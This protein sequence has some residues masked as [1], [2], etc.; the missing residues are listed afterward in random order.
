MQHAAAGLGRPAGDVEP[1]PVEP[2]PDEPA[3][4]GRRRSRARRRR[5]SARAPP[6][7]RRASRHG[8]GGAVRACA[9]TRCPAARPGPRPGRR[10]ATA[11]GSGARRQVRRTARSV[12]SASTDQN[13]TRSATTAAASQPVAARSPPRR[14]AS[15]ITRG[16]RPLERVDAGRRPG[17]PRR[18]R[19]ATRPPAAARSAGC[20]AGATG[21][22]PARAPA[23]SRSWMRPARWLSAPADLAHLRRPGR[24][25][26]A[27]PGRR[28]PAGARPRPGRRSAGPACGPAGRRRASPSSE[29]RQR[30]AAASTS[31]ARATPRGQLGRRHE[32][33]DH[34]RAVRRPCT[35]DQRSPGRRRRSAV[36]AAARARPARP[37]R[38]AAPARRAPCPSGRKTVT[39]GRLAASCST[40]EPQRRGVAGADQR[41]PSACASAVAAAHRAVLGDRADQQGQ[42]HQERDQDQRGG[43]RDQQRQP[44]PHRRRPGVELHADAAHGVQV[45]RLLRGLAELAAQPGQV[46]V[47]GL[48]GAAVRAAATPR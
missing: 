33:P 45:A 7:G 6:A 44:A 11:T 46:H 25:R 32:R 21:R 40:V 42:R 34:R 2:R 36:S 43:R 39:G 20:A 8:E 35:G 4:R 26:P 16:D 41:R 10:P 22:R 47:D 19:A 31:Q 17:P 24:A 48:V 13:A 12:S 3:A 18:G 1:R 9:R 14:R 27:R 15:R 29:Q 28:R 37:R 5:R 30:R 23:A 38:C